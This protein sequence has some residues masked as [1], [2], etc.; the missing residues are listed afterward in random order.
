MA[1]TDAQPPDMYGLALYAEEASPH[2]LVRAI[3]FLSSVR[4]SA[5]DAADD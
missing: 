4:S 5:L 3:P 1:T 2:W